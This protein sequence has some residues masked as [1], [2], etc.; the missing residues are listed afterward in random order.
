MT[1]RTVL[2]SLLLLALILTLGVGCT[3]APHNTAVRT[4]DAIVSWE[5]T[6]PG[7]PIPAAQTPDAIIS[8]D[9]TRPGDLIPAGLWGSN[10]TIEAPAAEMVE[11]P[12]FVD[13]SRQ[14]GVTTIRWPGGN[15]ASAYDWKT[16]EMIEPGGRKLMDDRVDMAGIL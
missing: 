4:P 11:H 14:I 1:Q 5:A 6:R 13:A 12:T 9:A 16:N 2:L 8:V 3:S 10:L 15:H 7:D